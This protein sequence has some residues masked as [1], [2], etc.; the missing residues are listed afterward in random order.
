MVYKTVSN[1][2]ISKLRCPIKLRGT[3]LPL[4]FFMSELSFAFYFSQF[5]PKAENLTWIFPDKFNIMW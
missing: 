3:I 2:I 4:D 1:I 5:P